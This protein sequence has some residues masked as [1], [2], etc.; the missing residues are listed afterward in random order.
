[1]KGMTTSKASLLCCIAI[2][3]NSCTA[4]ITD[5][6]TTF[7]VVDVGEGEYVAANRSIPWGPDTMRKLLSGAELEAVEFCSKQ[8]KTALII[9]RKYIDGTGCCASVGKVRF[10]C[11]AKQ[12]NDS[13]G[14][15]SLLM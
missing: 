13:S 15:P 12:L 2:I 14:Q 7:G 9:E 3:L 4:L 11:I 1:M 5:I 8:N 10:R 6:R